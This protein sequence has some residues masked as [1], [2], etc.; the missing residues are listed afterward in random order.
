MDEVQVVHVHGL[1]PRS[2]PDTARAAAEQVHQAGK[3]LVLTAY[4]LSDPTGTDEEQYSETLGTLVELADAVVT[5]TEPAAAEIRD[6]WSI[7]PV[8]LP[9]P[10]AVDFVRMHR[11]RPPRQ[12]DALVVGTHLGSLQGPTD[13][14]AFVAALAEAVATMGDAYL[15]VHVHENVLDPGSTSFN[16]NSVRRIEETVQAVGGIMA[17]HR[18]LSDAQL[19]DHLARLDV[20]VVPPTPGSHSIWPEACHDLGTHVVLP[21]GAHAAAQR[22]CLTYACG[23]DGPDVGSMVKALRKAHRQ[24]A[25]TPADPAQRWTERV[26]IA[27]RLRTLYEQQIAKIEHPTVRAV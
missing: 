9:H 23:P 12:C 11:E 10:H 17:T 25:A 1:S 18:P 7:E 21:E 2:T 15:L 19:W 22:P 6:R 26:G 5:L 24:G 27:E 13:H 8:V 16:L 14:E 20:S 3:P 4:H